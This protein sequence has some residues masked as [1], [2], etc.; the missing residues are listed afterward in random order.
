M[1][2]IHIQRIFHTIMD[3]EIKDLNITQSDSSSILSILEI[4]KTIPI[5]F[6]VR[7]EYLFDDGTKIGKNI[8]R[9]KVNIDPFIKNY[10]EI[11]DPERW[12]ERWDI[13]NWGIILA[14]HSNILVGGAIIA[15]KTNGVQILEKRDDLAVLWDIRIHP[16]YR[17]RGVGSKLFKYVLNWAKKRNCRDLK[18]ET[19]NNNVGAFEFYFKMGCELV[20]IN[21]NAYKEFPDEIQLIFHKKINSN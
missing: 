15:W 13:S 6:E 18:I 16:D 11:E 10:D 21:K 12:V 5:T 14:Y 7:S 8:I 19:Q 2:N 9:F 4:Y 1:G 20:E 17:K 3:C